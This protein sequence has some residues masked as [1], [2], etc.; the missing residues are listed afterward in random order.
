MEVFPQHDMSEIRLMDQVTR[1]TREPNSA[2]SVR[3][4]PP[5][6]GLSAATAHRTGL[7]ALQHALANVWKLDLLCQ[8]A[9]L[10]H[11]VA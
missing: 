11:V 6:H 4:E 2:H 9:V 7:A 10:I 1:I 3:M 5:L 8:G